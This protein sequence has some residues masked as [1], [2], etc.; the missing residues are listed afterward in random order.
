MVGFSNSRR[1]VSTSEGRYLRI[2]R[3]AF[4][5]VIGL[6]AFAGG[7]GA[8]GAYRAA[9]APRPTPAPLVDSRSVENFR[10]AITTTATPTSGERVTWSSTWTLCWD[11]FPGA[12]AYE[13]QAMTSE[14]ASTRIKRVDGPCFSVELAAG[15][16]LAQ[17]VIEKRDVQLAVQRSHL[18]YRVRATLG[19]DIVTTWSPAIDAGPA[20]M[21]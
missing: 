15:D 5:L 2:R 7:A 19:G 13:V 20:G 12:V 6:A 11:P 18:A 9:M 8:V 4:L 21:R 16:D 14:S 3:T 1:T 17:E 10:V